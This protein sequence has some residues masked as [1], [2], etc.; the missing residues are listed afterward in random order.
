MLQQQCSHQQL[1]VIFQAIWVVGRCQLL[2]VVELRFSAQTLR[3]LSYW[4]LAQVCSQL[5]KPT[6][7]LALWFHT[8]CV[9]VGQSQLTLCCPMHCRSMGS[10]VHGNYLSQNTGVGSLFL[11][12]GIFPTEGSNPGHPH[13]RRIP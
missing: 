3:S 1:I 2:A 5:L 8:W 12:Q 10:S 13:C 4:V 7:L 11:L 9:L 6:L